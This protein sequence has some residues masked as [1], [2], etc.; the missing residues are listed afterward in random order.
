M[1]EKS[2]IAIYTSNQKKEI[3]LIRIVPKSLEEA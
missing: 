3:M 2:K 1:I